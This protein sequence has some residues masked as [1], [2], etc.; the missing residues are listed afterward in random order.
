MAALEK[1]E[2]ETFEPGGKYLLIFN[3]GDGT[4]ILYKWSIHLGGRLAFKIKDII[5]RRFMR[6]FQAFE[7]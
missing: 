3:L 7:N 2:L 5:D 6:S 1:E 4:G